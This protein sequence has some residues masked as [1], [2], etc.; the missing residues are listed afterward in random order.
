[1]GHERHH[2]ELL[3]GVTVTDS[4]NI[5]QASVKFITLVLEG[6]GAA[7]RDVVLLEDDDLVARFG[8]EGRGVE[9]PNPRANHNKIN[10]VREFTRFE[11]VSCVL[12]RSFVRQTSRGV[13]LVA[14]RP[15][16]LRRARRI[17]RTSTNCQCGQKRIHHV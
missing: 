9:T 6:V 2:Y 4:T 17:S 1:M 5:V 12:R 7:S 10:L 11:V 3:S 14:F 15:L 8:E 16:V 13:W